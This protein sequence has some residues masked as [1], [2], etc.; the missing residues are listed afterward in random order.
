[1]YLGYLQVMSR[2]DSGDDKKNRV[3]LCC[4]ERTF[5]PWER[6]TGVALI[7]FT[8]TCSLANFCSMM[9]ILFIQAD[10]L[11]PTRWHRSAM[12]TAASFNS[13]LL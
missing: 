6:T 12:V 1:M 11:D 9:C 13:F 5:I 7:N 3:L 10:M 8:L 2:I 4:G